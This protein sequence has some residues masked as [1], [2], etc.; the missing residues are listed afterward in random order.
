MQDEYR[1]VRSVHPSPSPLPAASLPA[2]ARIN[3]PPFIVSDTCFSVLVLAHITVSVCISICVCYV[4]A[5]FFFSFPAIELMLT[6]RRFVWFRGVI[7]HNYRHAAKKK[8][9][10]CPPAPAAGKRSSY[11]RL[12]AALTG[13]EPPL[14]TGDFLISVGHVILLKAFMVLGLCY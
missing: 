7:F 14:R 3:K 11:S 5:F 4:V 1:T 6:A 9:L 2:Q 10:Y 8:R 12:A 13:I